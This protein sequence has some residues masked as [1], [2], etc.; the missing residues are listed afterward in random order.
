MYCQDLE[1]MG[2]NCSWAQLRVHS[3]CVSVI[4]EP[5]YQGLSSNVHQVWSKWERVVSGLSY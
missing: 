4:L 3:T 1:V 5:K 2:L